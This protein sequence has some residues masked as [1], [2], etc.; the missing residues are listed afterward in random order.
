MTGV[1]FG[2]MFP[3]INCG[4][5]S[6]L[7]S[8]S[9]TNNSATVSWTAITGATSYNVE[10]EA[11]GASSWT[12]ITGV[13][14]SSQPLSGLAPATTYNYAVATVCSAGTSSYSATSSFTTLQNCGTP[15]G[16]SSS[17]ITANT[18]T[19]SWGAVSGAVSYNL[20]YEA[21]GA[22]GWTTLTGVTSASYPLTGLS[23]STTYNFAVAATCS[24][25]TGPYSSSSSFTTLVVCGIPSGLS[26]SFI[27]ANTATVSWG[28]V[29][30]ATSYNLEYEATG[31]IR[32]DYC[33]RCYFYVVPVVRPFRFYYL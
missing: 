21:S 33:N 9:V 28:A 12:T 22:S 19:V 18:A 31:C 25:G 4:T 7:T 15:S 14:S 30:N 29:T 16:L 26:S 5:P 23:A 3:S 6:G 24:A 32:L 13:T 1:P 8:S 17:S 10:Y 27:T 11:S 20:E 2:P